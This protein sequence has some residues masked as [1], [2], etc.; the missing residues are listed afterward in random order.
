[1]DY[2]EIQN[3]DP[4]TI[5]Q[6]MELGIIPGQ[7]EQSQSDIQAAQATQSAPGPYGRQAGGLYQA[8]NPMEHLANAL[9]KFKARDAEADARAS[10]DQLRQDQTSARRAFFDAYTNRGSTPGF[11]PMANMLRIR[12]PHAGGY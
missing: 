6:L 8:A 3:L 1:M 2:A 9:R 4:A 11:N 7:L 5:Q 10:A 12:N